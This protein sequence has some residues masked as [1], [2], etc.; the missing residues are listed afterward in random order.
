MNI[1]PPMAEAR[2]FRLVGVD[3]GNGTELYPNGDQVQ[4]MSRGR[5]QTPS[6]DSA[7]CSIDQILSDIDTGLPDGNRYTDAPKAFDRAAWRVIVKHARPTCEA[8]ARRVI[9]VWLKSGLLIRKVYD[10]PATRKTVNGFWVD[11]AKSCRHDPR[12]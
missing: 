7:M 12:H 5:R 11:P 9:R 2:W 1:L 8:A 6:R 3:I 4:T 10:S